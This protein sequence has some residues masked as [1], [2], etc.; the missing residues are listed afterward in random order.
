MENWSELQDSGNLFLFGAIGPS[1]RE[2]S[3]QISG[4]KQ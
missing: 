1:V 4:K 2:T 3:Y